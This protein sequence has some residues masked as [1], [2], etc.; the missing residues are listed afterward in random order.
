MEQ[1]KFKQ[2]IFSSATIPRRI[3]PAGAVR[4]REISRYAAMPL[5]FNTL[6]SSRKGA[7]ARIQRGR[8]KSTELL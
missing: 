8:A 7:G 1:K 4:L 2:D 6:T 3:A 5:L